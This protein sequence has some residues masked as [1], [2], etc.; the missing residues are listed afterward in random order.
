[1]IRAES[2]EMDPASSTP[3][4]PHLL[5]FVVDGEDS[6]CLRLFTPIKLTRLGPRI[7]PR[8][9]SIDS[10]TEKGWQDWPQEGIK[11]PSWSGEQNKRCQKGALQQAGTLVNRPRQRSDGLGKY[12]LRELLK[13]GRSGC[14]RLFRECRG[15][16]QVQSCSCR[17]GGSRHLSDI[18]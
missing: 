12:I 4:P 10:I 11:T 13:I 6:E 14:L 2:R 16:P 17:A 3:R 5:R 7:L 15:D 8:C 18:G 1:M 9:A